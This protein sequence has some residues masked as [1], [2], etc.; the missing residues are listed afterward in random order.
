MKKRIL[1]VDDEAMILEGL[2]RMLRSMR[3]EWEMEF[4]ESAEAALRLLGP[5]ALRCHRLRHA[6]AAHER[7]RTSG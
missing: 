3:V 1:F 6:H 4:V 2:Q 5:K 7:G